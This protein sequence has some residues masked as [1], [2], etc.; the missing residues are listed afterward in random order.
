MQG[1][2]P[3]FQVDDTQDCHSG[4]PEGLQR[5]VTEKVA[6]VIRDLR[7]Q[8]IEVVQERSLLIFVHAFDVLQKVEVDVPYVVDQLVPEF[9]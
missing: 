6:H 3:S 4:I 8:K 7:G 2:A 5:I 1:S 9:G